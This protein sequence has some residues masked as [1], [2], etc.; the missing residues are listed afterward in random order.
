MEQ[1][2]SKARLSRREFLR[3]SGVA[4][5]GFALSSCTASTPGA[6][7]QATLPR[8]LPSATNVTLTPKLSSPPAPAVTDTPLP[9]ATATRKPP[10][11][12]RDI[13]DILGIKIGTYIDPQAKFWENVPWKEV[14]AREFNYG[15]NSLY[16]HVLIPKQDEFSFGLPDSQVDFALASKMT[17]R[18]ESLVHS[19]FLPDWLKNGSFTRDQMIKMF[20]N[21][22]PK[23]MNRYKDKIQDW[24]VVNEAGFIYAGW[25]FFENVIG[26]EYVEIAFELARQTSPS[27]TLMYNDFGNESLL[28]PKYSQTKDIIA[29]LKKKNL[30][31][32]VGLQMHVAPIQGKREAFFVSAG[33]TQFETTTTELLEA[34]KSYDLPVHLTELDVDLRNITGTAQERLELQAQ[35]YSEIIDTAL[36]SGNCK[37]I[38]FWGFGDKYSWLEQT[39]FNGS[40][41]ADPTLFDDDLNPK[42]GYFS[43]Q[44]ELKKRILA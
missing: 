44:E 22:I 23:M 40:D 35:V 4:S 1:N 43:I 28:G 38:T 14:A 20:E 18:G 26:R 6:T 41:Q 15:V 42:P 19:A 21:Y 24:I 2:Q 32:A 36:K 3:L 16:W 13:A 11:A 34:I 33:N 39:A 31:D 9:T 7:A 5:M 17:I 30:I 8:N 12:L 29:A 37:H 27:A 25:D 10:E